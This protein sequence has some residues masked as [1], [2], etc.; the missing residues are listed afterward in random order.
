MWFWFN[1]VLSQQFWN[2]VF[3]IDLIISLL[4]F[5]CCTSK[6]IFRY[7]VHIYS[8]F[9]LLAVEIILCVIYYVVEL[10]QFDFFI[11]NILFQI[12]SLNNIKKILSLLKLFLFYII[13]TDIFYLFF[14]FDFLS[15][16][17][18]CWWL[19]CWFQPY[20][21]LN[22]Y[23]RI[24]AHSR[25]IIFL[26][27]KYFWHFCLLSI[28]WKRFQTY[29]VSY[30]FGTD[31]VWVLMVSR[32]VIFKYFLHFLFQLFFLLKMPRLELFRPR[33][34]FFVIIRSSDFKKFVTFSFW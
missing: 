5:V 17:K 33:L 27:M 7:H 23:L 19:I 11:I 1:L 12:Y 2:T 6:R 10:T 26:H 22:I 24:I 21:V 14:L 29:R 4:F 9:V 16:C 34:I 18:E 25:Y 13:K 30:L 3:L 8:Y 15:R 31:V 20:F 32:K 28:L